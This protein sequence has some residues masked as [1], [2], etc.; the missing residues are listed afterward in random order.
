MDFVF[1]LIAQYIAKRPALVD[2]IRHN[3]WRN[4]Y[5]SIASR[6]GTRTY[7]YRAWLFNPYEDRLGNPIKRNWFMRLLPS[8]RLHEIMLPDDD[9][10]LHDHPWNARTIILRG[11]YDEV[12]LEDGQLVKHVR[13]AGTTARLNFGEFHRIA[14][15]GSGPIIT[16]FITGKYRGTWG[17]LVDG[18]KVPWREYLAQRDQRQA[19]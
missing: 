16:L 12:R 19:A 3:A 6:D 17:F 15:K 18:K 10:H 7:M 5:S 4:P 8:I 2:R 14:K 1:R 13:T 11:W 9:P